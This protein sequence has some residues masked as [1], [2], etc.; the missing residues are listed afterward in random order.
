MAAG[1]GGG[2]GLCRFAALAALLA[3]MLLALLRRLPGSGQVGWR[4][5]LANL[6]RRR[7]PSITQMVALASGLMAC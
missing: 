7:A 5:G 2:A 4:Y 1:A 6:A 3:W